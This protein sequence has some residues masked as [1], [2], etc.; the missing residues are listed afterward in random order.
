MTSVLRPETAQH[1]AESSGFLRISRRLARSLADHRPNKFS[2]EAA[3]KLEEL[4]QRHAEDVALLAIGIAGGN[5]SDVVSA[6]DVEAASKRLAPRRRQVGRFMEVLGGLVTGAGLS[7][8]IA[9]AAAPHPSLT[10]F[11][12]ATTCTTVGATLIA[13]ALTSSR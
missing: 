2:P 8:F 7:G 12:A 13:A 9:A 10:M 4:S 5:L 6:S 11:A 1:E 3:T